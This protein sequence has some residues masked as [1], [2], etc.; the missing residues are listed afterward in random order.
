MGFHNPELFASLAALHLI[1]AITA[2]SSRNGAP[3]VASID[4]HRRAAL[5]T[6]ITRAVVQATR[7]VLAV[8]AAIA[9]ARAHVSPFTSRAVIR[10]SM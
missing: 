10:A 4:S 6:S 2:G 3:G 7:P 5:I 9:S 1:G 8:V